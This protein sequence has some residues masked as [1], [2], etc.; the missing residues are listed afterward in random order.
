M[1]DIAV[2]V[3]SKLAS[4]NRKRRRT[5]KSTRANEFSGIAFVKSLPDVS[6]STSPLVYDQE[7]QQVYYNMRT[8]WQS[9]NVD[10]LIVPKFNDKHV[11]FFTNN[12]KVLEFY[13]FNDEEIISIQLDGVFY[14]KLEIHAVEGYHVFI[15]YVEVR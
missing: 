9:V 1:N 7:S 5:L 3:N 15:K 14:D 13:Y 11:I 10:S 8:Y 2:K 12:V 6:I 4:S